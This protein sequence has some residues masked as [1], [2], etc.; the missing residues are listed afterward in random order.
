R[1]ALPFL[2][3]ALL[4]TEALCGQTMTTA[5]LT[6]V[7]LD[8]TGTPLSNVLTTAASADLGVSLETTTD[9]SGR[10]VFAL[11]GP[12]VYEVR[13]EAFG[14]RPVLARP[15]LLAAGDARSMTLSMAPAAPPITA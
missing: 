1:L 2:A 8:P 3:G 10:F 9:A 11:L 12:G 4:W 6:G 14:F 5:R 7:V 13:A 15:I